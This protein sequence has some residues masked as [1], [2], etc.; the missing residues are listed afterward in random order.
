M[1]CTCSIDFS[2]FCP[3]VDQK[4]P[5]DEGTCEASNRPKPSVQTINSGCKYQYEYL[6]AVVAT[7]R[8][9]SLLLQLQQYQMQFASYMQLSL[10]TVF[11]FASVFVLY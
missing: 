6:V 8:D 4:Q 2:G 1:A 7:G 3:V 9:S 11:L 10:A 5:V